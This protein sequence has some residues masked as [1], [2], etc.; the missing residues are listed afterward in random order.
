M[1]APTTEIPG[2]IAGTWKIDGTHSDVTFT[3]RHLGV[4][5]VRGRFDQ[6]DTTI[7]TAENVL[8]STVTTTIQAASID[9]NNEQ[10]DA[11]VRGEDFL[12]VEKYPT[13]T[14]TS[15]GVR[16]ED[17]EYLIDGDLT[18][19]GVTKPVTLTTELG[20][21]ADGQAP[22]SKVLGI[23]AATEVS[24]TEFG[25]GAGVPGAVVSDKIKIELDIEAGLQS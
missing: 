14:F 3:V 12:D 25:V 9:T 5:K 13:I 20:G 11:H 6:V 18:I 8:D 16:V 23:S 7:V 19:H 10:R 15:T 22:G 4:S 17:G 2:Y 21:F 1:S 24:R